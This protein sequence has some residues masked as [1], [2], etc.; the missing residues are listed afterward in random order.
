MKPRTF[1][2]TIILSLSIAGPL[3]VAVPAPSSLALVLCA[4]GSR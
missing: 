1:P 4:G 2:L 3:S